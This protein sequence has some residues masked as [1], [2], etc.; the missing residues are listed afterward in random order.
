MSAQT[1]EMIEPTVRQAI[2]ISSTTHDFEAW[3]AS[4]ATWSPR[5]A[6]R[7]HAPF[8]GETRSEP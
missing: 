5:V 7:A 8:R 2:R 4:Q 6:C 3:V 1:R